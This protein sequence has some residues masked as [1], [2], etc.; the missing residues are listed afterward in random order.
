MSSNFKVFYNEWR[1]ADAVRTGTS[2]VELNT[3]LDGNTPQRLS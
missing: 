1:V 2:N 3:A